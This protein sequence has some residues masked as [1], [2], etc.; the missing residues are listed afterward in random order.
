M[1]Y[2]CELSLIDGEMERAKLLAMELNKMD[3]LNTQVMYY[4]VLTHS[5][6]KLPVPAWLIEEPWPD[7]TTEDRDNYQR[8]MKQLNNI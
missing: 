6:L 1:L 3:P 5:V 8:A 7:A 2:E 4:L